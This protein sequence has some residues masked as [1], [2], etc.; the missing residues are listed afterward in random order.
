MPSE[1]S[2]ISSPHAPFKHLPPATLASFQSMKHLKPFPSSQPWQYQSPLI[3]AYP[4][5]IQLTPITPHISAPASLLQIS[6]STHNKHPLCYGLISQLSCS[7]LGISMEGL[8][9]D[10]FPP[11]MV[12][13]CFKSL[14]IFLT[15]VSASSFK[16]SSKSRI[17]LDS[18]LISSSQIRKKH[19]QRPQVYRT[20]LT[21]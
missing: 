3:L 19:C 17:V 14:L 12:L 21:V 5:Y 6:I 7:C 1:L 9:A 11:W 16:D 4:L 15:S 8:G 20:Y 10:G 18:W 2:C 13:K